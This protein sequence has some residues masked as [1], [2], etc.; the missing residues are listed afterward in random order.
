METP[1]TKTAFK[2]LA[3]ECFPGEGSCPGFSI[4]ITQGEQ[5]QKWTHPYGAWSSDI[6]QIN[7]IE[8]SWKAPHLVP[9]SGKSAM[10]L[11]SAWGAHRGQAP[12]A[13]S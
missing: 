10:L 7:S 3:E 13:P 9:A 11:H 2:G 12:G 6:K 1:S 5:E 8:G 4:S